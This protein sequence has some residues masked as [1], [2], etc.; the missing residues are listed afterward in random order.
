[1]NFFRTYPDYTFLVVILIILFLGNTVFAV[2][3]LMRGRAENKPNKTLK[4]NFIRTMFL[5]IFD[6]LFTLF[7]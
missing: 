6:L 7:P 4:K 3:G 5:G 1:M 2:V